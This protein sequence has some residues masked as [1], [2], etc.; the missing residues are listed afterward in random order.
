ML[1]EPHK[2]RLFLLVKDLG[3]QAEKIKKKH[4]QINYK[5]DKSPLSE[6]DTFINNELNAFIQSTQFKNVI[7]EEN[8]QINFS[9][10]K[11]WEYFWLLDPIDGTKEFIKKNND[12][13][14]N[15][16]LCKRDMPIFSIV[17]APGRDEF[18]HAEKGKGSFLN[19]K[20]ISN[21]PQKSQSFNVVASKSHIN[22]ET[23][24]YIA[25]LESKRRVNLIQFGSS[26]KICKVAEGVAD[27]YPRFGPT[28]EWDTCAA[29]LILTEAGGKIENTRNEELK[30]N[31]V[32]LLNSF[33]IA[34][35]QGIKL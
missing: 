18:Y 8:K 10:R 25:M 30:Y 35:K 3:K 24:K 26:L 23:Q 15:I 19:G 9:E 5:D 14:I 2:T 7:S 21:A 20:I 11:S 1:S 33:F 31:K 12:Y 4:F 16:A 6:A 29:H 27:I 28:M 22:Q 34:T 13:T 32:D 17:F